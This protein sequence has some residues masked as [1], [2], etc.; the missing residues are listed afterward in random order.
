M[1]G[2]GGAGLL[3][4][5]ESYR[6]YLIAI[7]T[8]LLGLGFYLNYRSPKED[9]QEGEVC[10]QPS[11]KKAGKI[12]LWIATAA[13]ILFVAFPFL[14]F[15]TTTQ[16][17]VDEGQSTV[18]L[19]VQGMTCDACGVAIKVALSKLGGVKSAEVDFDKKA[20]EVAYEGEM[21]TAGEMIAAIQHLGYG[22]SL[23]E[24]QN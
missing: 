9:C 22:A 8:V 6:P 24:G 7:T 1:L 12:T 13:V 19:D 16:A 4:S 21:V 2:L 18:I 15:A 10:A 20:A 17:T 3:V 23:P 14:P 11:G 5:L